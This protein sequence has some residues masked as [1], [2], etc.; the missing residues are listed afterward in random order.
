MSC[1]RNASTFIGVRCILCAMMFFALH[2]PC[3]FL[4]FYA[5][6]APHMRWLC[7]ILRVGEKWVVANGARRKTCQ[8]TH[9]FK[10]NFLGEFCI[11]LINGLERQQEF[12]FTQYFWDS[13]HCF[14]CSSMVALLFYGHS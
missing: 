1:V 12:K 9:T 7:V 14:A 13:P 4:I 6:S 11:I 8:S 5:V 2:L 3:S 10:L